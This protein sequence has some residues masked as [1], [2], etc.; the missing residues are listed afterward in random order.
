MYRN[1]P[2]ESGYSVA[3]LLIMSRN[4]IETYWLP[5]MITINRN[6]I[7]NAFNDYSKRVKSIPR[8]LEQYYNNHFKTLIKTLENK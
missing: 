1:A 2:T 6:L 7:L 8:K 3:Q 5:L 4:L